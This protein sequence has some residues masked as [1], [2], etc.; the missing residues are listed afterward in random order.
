[1]NDAE[2]RD[3][4][5]QINALDEAMEL[6]ER[7]RADANAKLCELLP[8]ASVD[9]RAEWGRVDGMDGHMTITLWGRQ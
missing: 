7:Y 6:F 9:F 4:A 2:I 8:G 1:M 3:L 5:M